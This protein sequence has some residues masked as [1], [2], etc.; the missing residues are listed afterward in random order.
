M[1]YGWITQRTSL[2]WPEV[3]EAYCDVWS[4]EPADL[5]PQWAATGLTQPVNRA[6]T[7]WTCLAE[8]SAAEWAEWGI[9][10][11][12]HLSRVLDA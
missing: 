6:M 8:A 11:L 7:W 9:A 3:L 12:H 2:S 1:P 4:I 5:E 10:P